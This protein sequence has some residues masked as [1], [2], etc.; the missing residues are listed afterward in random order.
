MIKKRGLFTAGSV[1]IALAALTES[2]SRDW[3][4]PRP[5]TEVLMLIGAVLMFASFRG[6]QSAPQPAPQPVSTW[7][8][9]LYA[10]PAF[11]AMPFLAYYRGGLPVSS[12]V[13]GEV[14]AVMGFSLC[15]VYLRRQGKLR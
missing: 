7:R 11:I 9:I 2:F 4:S 13:G 1:L 12:I 6:R 10:L 14:M 3:R 15:I 8:Y 5:V